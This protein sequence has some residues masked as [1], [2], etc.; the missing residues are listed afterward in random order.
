MRRKKLYIPVHEMFGSPYGGAFGNTFSGVGSPPFWAKDL[1]D[2]NLLAYYRTDIVDG[3]LI[4][5]RPTGST[6]P[7][8]KGSLFSVAVPEDVP[9][10][11][12]LTSDV[13]TVGGGTAPTCAVDGTLSMTADF[14]DMSIHRAGVLWS[15]LPGINVDAT[16]ELDA[17]GNGHT[18]YLTDTVIVEAVDGTGTNWCNEMGFTVADGTQYLEPELITAIGAGWRIPALIDGSGCAAYQI[19]G[20]A[21]RFLI[22]GQSNASGRGIV[23]G[24]ETPSDNVWMLGNDNQLKVAYEPV[25][26]WT[27]QADAVSSDSAQPLASMHGFCLR[28][29]KDIADATGRGVL[30]IPTA[31][32]STTIAQW[33]PATDTLNRATLFGSANYRKQLAAPDGLDAIWWFGHE[34]SASAGGGM[35]AHRWI[36]MTTWLRESMADVPIIFAQL[37]KHQ[38][39]SV[40][41]SQLLAGT[42]SLKL[43][44]GYTPLPLVLGNIACDID[45]TD[46]WVD[47]HPVGCV[48]IGVNA[49]NTVTQTAGGARIV[50]DGSSVGFS[51]TGI[52]TIGVKYYLEI[53][54]SEIVSDGIKFYGNTE[55]GLYCTKGDGGAGLYKFTYTADT[56]L[57]AMY[58]NAGV[59]DSTIRSVKIW[60]YISGDIWA[61]TIDRHHAVVTFD[62]PMQ[63]IVHLNQAA[64][65]EVGRR[66]A[67][68]T[69]QHVLGES[70]NGTGPRLASS[71]AFT[72]P[73]G[74]KSKVKIKF[75]KQISTGGSTSYNGQF[76]VFDGVT[77]MTIVSTV[78]DPAD[79]SAVLITMSATATGT[80]TVSYGDVAAAGNNITL[81]DVVKDADNLPAPQFSAQTVI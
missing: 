50:S 61:T 80:V 20:N 72:H 65:I 44:S 18:L 38:T 25:D 41:S 11:G 75:D 81:L 6:T 58:R 79:T 30:L 40:N 74:D 21:L 51:I 15:Y 24:G 36:K 8:V 55:K 14:W 1:A 17:S 5:Y 19:A 16:F 22:G 70:V 59:S 77:A 3:R 27:G 10:T 31:K 52:T 57:L 45:F 2:G 46:A 73:S 33:A 4:A 29:G 9:Y 66:F 42:E 47:G 43:E 71:G 34:S 69:R 53:E 35:Y 49:T 68:A 12:I 48:L 63:D 39:A 32:G 7:Q 13:I 26:D 60:P 56:T 54:M 23:A 78:R 67:L 62:L 37:A 28:A 64:Q 76:K